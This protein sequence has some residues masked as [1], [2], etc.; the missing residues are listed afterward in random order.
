M[1]ATVSVLGQFHA[2]YLARELERHG[3]LDRLI[4]SYP[5]WAVNRWGVSKDRVKSLWPI[6][7][8]RRAS[9]HWLRHWMRRRGSLDA[10]YD[11]MAARSIPPGTDV[12][13]AWSGSAEITL[14]RAQEEGATIIV[15][16]GSS[17]I[18]S[19]REIL[20][21]EYSRHGLEP[22]IPSDRAVDRQEREYELADRIAVP[23]CFVERSFVD[24]G[25]EQ[26]KLLRLPYGV[27][28]DEFEPVP[29]ED[30]V[31]RVVFAGSLGV[32]KG[33]KYLLRA[34]SELDLPRSEL[35]LLGRVREEAKPWFA[36]HG[37]RIRHP[38]HVPQKE[39]HRWYSQGSVFAL[40]SIE[41]GMA[42][43]QL[44]AM[45]CGL[46]LICTPNTGGE[47]LVREGQEGFVLPIRDVEALKDRLLWCYEH[48]D[49]CRE[50]GHA[51]RERVLEHF[52]WRHYGERVVA[53]YDEVL[54]GRGG[55]EASTLPGATRAHA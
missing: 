27:D 5:A 16:R 4:T 20:E 11:R 2:F 15:E 49:K 8:A 6:E 12:V 35:L 46:P 52:T 17:H 32:R 26:E 50:M 48:K 9:P 14:R 3:V 28:P 43:V 34:F 7:L 47:D 37:D 33:T 22:D 54:R 24:R 40:P 41:E 25:I 1:R 10:A 53:A 39:L 30:D 29:K 21:E 13:V 42:C 44:Q 23:S 45:A 38:G 31:F 19:Q 18:R 36:G 55:D 51:A